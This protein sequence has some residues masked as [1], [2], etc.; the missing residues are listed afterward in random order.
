MKLLYLLLGFVVIGLLVGCV[1]GYQITYHDY[2]GDIIFKDHT[3]VLTV[4]NYHIPFA[5]HRLDSE[6][7]EFVAHPEYPYSTILPTVNFH[8]NRDGSLTIP[9][10]PEAVITV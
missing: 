4:N 6:S 8:V 10:Y 1:S 2:Q 9:D 5:W 7:N 3:G